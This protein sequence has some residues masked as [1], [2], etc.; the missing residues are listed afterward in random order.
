[1]TSSS[2]P[3]KG[4]RRFGALVGLIIVLTLISRVVTSGQSA[5]EEGH[6]ALIQGQELRA[7][8]SYREALSWYLPLAAPWRMEAG[9]ALWELHE[10]QLKEGRLS[11]AVQS[12]QSMRAGLRSADS[13]WRPNQELKRQVDDALAPLMA[14]WEAEDAK[15]NGRISLGSLEERR[16][17]HARLLSK[18]A[19][20]NRLWGL[21]ASLGF[22]LWVGASLKALKQNRDKPMPLYL[23]SALGLLAFLAGLSLA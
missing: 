4:S 18:D 6:E 7:V 8:T 13:L 1:M 15:A 14:R 5:L 12:L 23:L 2:Q 20:P 17:H 19:R 22:F 3:A 9:D 21:I 10:R 11:A 16:T